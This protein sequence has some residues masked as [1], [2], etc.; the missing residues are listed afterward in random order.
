MTFHLEGLTAGQTDIR[1][2]LFENG[3]LIYRSP[4]VPVVVA[5]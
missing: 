1:F 2:R 5:P 3:A 4:W